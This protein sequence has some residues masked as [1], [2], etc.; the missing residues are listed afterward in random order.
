MWRSLTA[1]TRICRYYDRCPP[2]CLIG[3][4]ADLIEGRD[5]TVVWQGKAYGNGGNAHHWAV[6]G[7]TFLAPARNV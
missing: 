4:F 7:L 5:V 6:K 1:R 2:L 3:L